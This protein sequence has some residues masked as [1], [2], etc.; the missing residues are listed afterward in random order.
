MNVHGTAQKL[1]LVKAMLKQLETNDDY[2][3]AFGITLSA[4][5][6]AAIIGYFGT[7]IVA[8]AGQFSSAHYS[9]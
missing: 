8:L 5:L 4:S 7:A 3:T 6:F 1:D 9:K 2:P